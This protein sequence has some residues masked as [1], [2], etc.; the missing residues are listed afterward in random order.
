MAID[1]EL[2]QANTRARAAEAHQKAARSNHIQRLAE[3]EA[4]HKTVDYFHA[5]L[6][7]HG[8]SDLAAGLR[9]A[10]FS[11]RM[12]SA[13]V[14]ATA[15]VA[16]KADQQAAHLTSDSEAKVSD[17]HE[18]HDAQVANEEALRQR[19]VF[20]EL[21]DERRNRHQAE[22]RARSSTTAGG[23]PSEPVLPS[24][25]SAHE[26]HNT[27]QRPREAEN[28]RKPEETF[29]EKRR[30]EWQ[31]NTLRDRP[32]FAHILWKKEVERAFM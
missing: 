16:A 27:P 1:T 20:R 29:G 18:P 19:E 12:A 15:A 22:Q 31:A 4:A 23:A 30:S 3:R 13:R 8:Q 17:G 9:N 26:R 14:E 25:P 2:A 21:M 10:E 28:A 5:Q 24:L 7:K 6:K 11:L 32:Q